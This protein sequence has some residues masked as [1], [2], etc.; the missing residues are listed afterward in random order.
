MK[1]ILCLSCTPWRTIPTR[2]QQLMIRL[3][4]AQVLFFEPP[5]RRW[6]DPGR[7][8]RPGLTVY[9]LPPVLEAEERHRLLF[10]RHYRKL[11][12]YIQRRMDRHRFR[13]PLLWCTSPEQVHLLEYLPHRGVVYDCYRDWEDFSP[14]W[15]SDLAL[16]ADVIFA[17]SPGL[18]HHLAPCNDNIALLPNGVNHLM[19]TRPNAECPR[20]L[21]GIPGPV[22]GYCGVVWEDLDLV[23]VAAAAGELPGCTFV[24]LGRVEDSPM[25]RHL[26]RFPNVRFLGRR[27]PVEVPDYLARFD[28]CLNLR[29]WSEQYD[30]II[31]TR[32]Y[33]Y[34]SSGKPTVSMFYPEQVEHFPDVV[35]GAHSPE[36]FARL[37]RRALAETGDWARLRRQEH[38]ASAA[39]SVRA[40]Q[41]TRILAAIGLY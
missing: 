2:T 23:P 25:V 26:E 1:Q 31:P 41:V 6:K 27:P 17:A 39:W 7:N 40:Q 38:G 14:V 30:D 28:V 8:M 18:R 36:E 11:A 13:E 20:E 15:E 29:R 35:Y 34:L 33:E 3:K 19:F 22:L 16:A 24:F 10:R 5:G 9:T 4:D 21:A 12:N 37:C 32:V